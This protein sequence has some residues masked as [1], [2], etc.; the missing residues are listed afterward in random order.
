MKSGAD[1]SDYKIPNNKGFRY[2]FVI[3]DNYSNYVRAIL[4]KIKYGE[5]IT[6]EFSN[7]QSTSKRS[8]LNLKKDRDKEWYNNVFQ[9][10]SKS[11]NIQHYSRFTDKGPSRAEVVNRTLR[12]LL[13][14]PVFEKV[15]ANLISEMPPSVIKKYNK[16]IQSSK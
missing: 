13:K 9:N 12:N 8:P 2:M 1:F 4:L 3:I 14:K 7:I 16:K 10:I 11:K 15:S 6:D 5:T